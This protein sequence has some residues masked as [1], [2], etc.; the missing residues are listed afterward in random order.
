MV[1]VVVSVCYRSC[2]YIPTLLNPSSLPRLSQGCNI[3]VTMYLQPCY[4]L[5][6]GLSEVE[7]ACTRSLSWNIAIRCLTQLHPLRDRAVI[8]GIGCQLR[9]VTLRNKLVRKKEMGWREG[10]RWER[11][12]RE[13]WKHPVYWWDIAFCPIF[14]QKACLLIHVLWSNLQH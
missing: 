12:W 4:N 3:V 10:G 7:Y 13:M 14:K 6:N 9:L 5:G 8:D 2:T 11:E 1:S